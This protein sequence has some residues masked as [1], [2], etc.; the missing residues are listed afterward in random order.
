MNISLL[1]ANDSNILDE[2]ENTTG[3]VQQYQIP[4]VQTRNQ[5][6]LPLPPIIVPDPQTSEATM[7]FI[8]SQYQPFFQ[9]V[10]FRP[11]QADENTIRKTIATR[12]ASSKLTHW[13]MYAGAQLFRTL[14]QDGEYADVKR[15]ESLIDRLGRLSCTATD[16][17]SL[18]DM[19]GRL[20]G[21]LELTFLKS[22][23]SSPRSTYALLQ[24]IA[25]LF[26]QVAFADPTLWPRDSTCN[27][28]SLAHA[29]G[30]TRRELGRFIFI[31]LITSLVFGTPPLVEYD[32][33]HPAVQTDEKH[34]I[35][36]V[37][38]CPAE[39]ALSIA[40]INQWRAQHPKSYPEGL[41]W[42]EIEDR[43]CEWR[44]ASGSD[45]ESRRLVTRFA[46]QEGWRHAVLIYLYMG[47]CGVNNY[48]RRVQSSVRQISRLYEIV[49]SE[50]A[51]GMHLTVPFLLAGAAICARGEADRTKFRAVIAHMGHK[52]TWLLRGMDFGPVLDHLW[53][54]VAADGGPITWSDYVGSRR[55]VMEVC[56]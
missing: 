12:V 6:D 39:F 42:K 28:I 33:S 41:P 14:R 55:A 50:F 24:Q 18:D 56:A 47:M 37:H 27:G 30:S 4:T 54:G 25:P 15:F 17:K 43:I 38:G 44:P 22:L 21:A 46:A 1:H 7:L 49:S 53:Y 48:D 8:V 19:V 2:T 36:G 45:S 13:A 10:F 34:S 51:A 16:D 26:M 5:R 52:K 23:T 20:S 31:E 3:L 40:A 29:F 11:A 35:E 32:T 9:L